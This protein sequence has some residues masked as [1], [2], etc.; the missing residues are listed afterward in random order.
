MAAHGRRRDLAVL[1]SAGATRAQLMRTA[2]AETAVVAVAGVLLG[3]AVT[4]PPL[5]GVASG[6]S[7][8]T[9]TAV[10]L[11][12]DPATPA[13]AAAA[14]LGPALLST[15]VVT[16]RTTRPSGEGNVS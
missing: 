1:R 14:C 10:T 12:L 11:H 2:L 16:W 8:A 9:G 15:A 13:A 6:L 7:E 4:I 5:A 3:L